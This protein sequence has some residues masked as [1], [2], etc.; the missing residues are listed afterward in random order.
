MPRTLSI[1]ELRALVGQEVAASG[2]L[3]VE[4]SRL[5]RFAEATEDYQW[6]HLDTERARRE[7]PYGGTIA[8][9]FLSLSLLSHLSAQ[10]LEISGCRMRINYGLNRVRFPAAV[11]AGARVRGRFTLQSVEDVEGGVQ[12]LWAVT[13]E[14]E[15]GK[16]PAVFAEWL[17][18]VYPETH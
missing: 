11:P 4:Q 1:G 9:G 13:V 16:K 10:A 8:H 5:Q 12:I 18:R 7:S 3:A 15:G 2:W 14:I 17:V 6:I